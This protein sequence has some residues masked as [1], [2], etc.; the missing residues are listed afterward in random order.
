MTHAQ[1]PTYIETPQILLPVTYPTKIVGWFI[2]N[3][4]KI[5][6]TLCKKLTPKIKRHI[7]TKLLAPNNIFE[8]A[9]GLNGL[10]EA[11][12]KTRRETFKLWDLVH[13][14]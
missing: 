5:L 7:H 11:N 3:K 12:C 14:C 13:L 10:A 6:Y 2:P 1:S 8:L 4:Q 9:P